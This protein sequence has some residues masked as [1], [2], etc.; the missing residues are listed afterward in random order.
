MRPE[1]RRRRGKRHS[2]PSSRRRLQRAKSRAL[3][4]AE[5]HPVTIDLRPVDHRGCA[6]T[7]RLQPP[8]VGEHV[9]GVDR[10]ALD[11]VDQP[12]QVRA[13]G[14][15][16]AN[17]IVRSDSIGPDPDDSCVAKAIVAR[18]ISSGPKRSSAALVI[19]EY[20]SDGGSGGLLVTALVANA[21]HRR[22]GSG[23]RRARDSEPVVLVEWLSRRVWVLSKVGLWSASTWTPLA[24][25]GPSQGRC[26]EHD[27][28]G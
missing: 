17:S 19:E 27:G 24:G 7:G 16:E 20:G 18:P 25:V 3:S 14:Q 13:T 12:A 5:V 28:P 6:D 15:Q 21:G 2:Q 23:V 1:G 22:T 11:E 10:V 26:P 8:R 9:V 4:D